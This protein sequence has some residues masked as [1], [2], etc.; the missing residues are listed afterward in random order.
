MR[1]RAI[2]PAAFWLLAYLAVPESAR[3]DGFRIPDQGAAASAQGAAFAAQADDPS[4]I[5]YNPA[6]MTQLRGLQLYG[7][8]NLISG[9]TNFTSAT[10]AKARSDNGVIVNPPPGSLFLTAS[11]K[12]FGPEALGN[13][14]LGIGVAAPFGLQTTY[15]ST[16]PLA[17]V[18]T[19]AAL[20]L[21]D[22]KPTMAY[23]LTPYLSIGAGLDIYTFSS[24]VGDGQS[25]QKRLA[26]P[27][28][29]P[30]GIPPGAVLEVNGVDTAVGFNFGFLITPLRTDGQPRLNIGVVYRSAATLNLS[31]DFLVDGRKL[32]GAKTQVKLPW[33]LTGAVGWW[34]IR[35]SAHEWKLEVDVDYADWSSFKS[36]DVRLSNGVTLPFPLNWTP[37][38]VVMAGT[39]FK[40]LTPPGLPGWQIAARA[41]YIHSTTPVPSRTV[42]AASPDADYNAFCVGVGL[43]CR[44]PG[45]F[46][47][48]LPCGR[49]E[50]PWWAMKAIGVDLSYQEVLYDPRR[51]TSADDPRVNGRWTTISHI[52]SISVR[53]NF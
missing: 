6:G 16:G 43:L 39:E 11:L 40:W 22:I 28:F 23:R 1:T 33:I 12:E 47:G 35:D 4:A 25:E 37:A 24:L 7:G 26:G 34:P 53:V 13:L 19:H 20:P 41:G 50:D 21:L 31:G 52:G 14:T 15:P 3:G 46:A 51:I 29:T 36:F 42:Q 9:S 48:L 44:G 30:L 45:R 8:A 38:T 49:P 5:Y 17:N 32:A 18:S 27:E 10:G 2:L